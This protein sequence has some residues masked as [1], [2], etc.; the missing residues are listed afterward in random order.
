MALLGPKKQPYHPGKQG[1]A[2]VTS[3]E[4]STGDDRKKGEM[5]GFQSF[6]LRGKPAATE[7]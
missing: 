1:N 3:V 7:V 5:S 2:K 6:W 4:T